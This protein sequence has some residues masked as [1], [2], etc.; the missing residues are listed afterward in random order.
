MN[1]RWL[2][3]NTLRAVLGFSLAIGTMKFVGEGNNTSWTDFANLLDT[4]GRAITLGEIPSDM[5]GEI[6]K[7]LIATENLF[8]GKEGILKVGY[9]IVTK[10][11]LKNVRKQVNLGQANA[12]EQIDELIKRDIWANSF[13]IGNFNY[14]LTVLEPEKG[15]VSDLNIFVDSLGK[16]FGKGGIVSVDFY[17]KS[18][19]YDPFGMKLSKSFDERGLSN[20]RESGVFVSYQGEWYE[21]TSKDLKMAQDRFGMSIPK[22]VLALFN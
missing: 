2:L 22:E 1:E 14:H 15:M 16:N 9:N 19:G 20:I 10:E 6:V 12:R 17:L 11:G 3:K 5:S 8:V 4:P 18:T 13:N 21:A 7:G